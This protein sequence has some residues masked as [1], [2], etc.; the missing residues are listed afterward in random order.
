MNQLTTQD[1]FS[2]NRVNLLITMDMITKTTTT[3][4]M[5]TIGLEVMMATSTQLLNLSFEQCSLIIKIFDTRHPGARHLWTSG[6]MPEYENPRDCSCQSSEEQASLLQ[7]KYDGS[8]NLR[9]G[10]WIFCLTT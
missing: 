5:S 10:Q 8:D 7:S 3:F 4:Y 6:K 2:P 9:I 1:V